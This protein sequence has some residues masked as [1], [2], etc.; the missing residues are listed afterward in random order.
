GATGAPAAR[1]TTRDRGATLRA[2][3]RSWTGASWFASGRDGERRKTLDERDDLVGVET[4]RGDEQAIDG[5][6]LQEREGEA[7]RQLVERVGRGGRREELAEGVLDGERG[8]SAELAHLLAE[9]LVGAAGDGE[10]EPG[11]E[12]VAAEDAPEKIER[13]GGAIG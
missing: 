4:P 5:E 3:S 11:V 12:A 10:L 1:R 9:A 6:A 8:A 7:R 13:D 2:E